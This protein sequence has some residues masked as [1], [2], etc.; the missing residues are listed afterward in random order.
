M[1]SSKDVAFDMDPE[2]LMKESKPSSMRQSGATAMM[3]PQKAAKTA[4]RV[5]VVAANSAIERLKQDQKDKNKQPMRGK[6][7]KQ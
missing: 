7:K 3:A 4:S 6:V 2:Q 1:I 5:A